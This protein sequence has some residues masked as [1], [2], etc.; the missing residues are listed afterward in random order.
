MKEYGMKLKRCLAMFLSV[1][2]LLTSANIGVLLPIRA[3]EAQAEKQGSTVTLGVLIEKN[4]DELSKEE[5]SIIT[6]GYLSA[7]KTYSYKMPSDSDD[8]ITVDEKS[9]TVTAKAYTDPIYGTVWVPVSFD[10]TD[11]SKAIAGYDNLPLSASGDVYVGTYELEETNPG[12]SFTVAVSYSLDM[13]MSDEDLAA[14]QQMLDASYALATDIALMQYLDAVSVI[15]DDQELADQIIDIS[16]GLIKDPTK[17]YADTILEFL[18]MDLEQLGNQSAIDLIYQ[19]VDGIEI[20]YV[21]EIDFETGKIEISEETLR[22]GKDGRNAA[23]ELYNQKVN[24]NALDLVAFLSK[25]NSASYL[26][27]V[28]VHGTELKS[29]LTGNYAAID[30][31]SNLNSSGGLKYVSNQISV[32]LEDFYAV[33]E[34]IYDE[35]NSYL[36]EM[37]KTVNSV[38]EL[39]ALIAELDAANSDAYNAINEKLAELDADTKALLAEYGAPE[40]VENIDDLTAMKNALV[41]AYTDAIGTINSALAS[42]DSDLLAQLTAAGAPAKITVADTSS[43]EAFV[44]SGDQDIADLEALRTALLKV[45]KDALSEANDMLQSMLGDLDADT[46]T[47]LTAAGAPAKITTVED[48]KTLQTALAKVKADV[49]AQI[50]AELQK[51]YSENADLAPKLISAGAPES[52]KALQDLVDLEAALIKARE[53]LLNTAISSANETLSVLF[54]AYPAI[55]PNTGLPKKIT[56]EAQLR[57]VAAKLHDLSSI[58]NK[59]TIDNMDQAISALDQLDEIIPSIG[60]AKDGVAKLESAESDLQAAADGLDALDDTIAEL[61]TAKTALA[62]M[63]PY[64]A[65]VMEGYEQLALL[66]GTA[67]PLLKQVES[68]MIQLEEGIATLTDKQQQLDM[69]I[70]V[71][72]AFCSTVEPAYNACVNDAWNAP[73]LLNDKADYN[74]LTT[75]A[76]DATKKDYVAKP[77][78]HVADAVVTYKMDMYDVTVEFKAAVVNPAKVDSAETIDLTTKTYVITLTKGATAQEILTEIAAKVDENAILTDWAIS[79]DN[80]D[81]TTNLLPE[82]LE[83]NITYTVTYAPKQL[84]VSF[85]EGYD[86]GTADMKVPYGYRMTLP[87]LVG[88]ATEEYTYT[89]NSENNIDQGTIVTI[90]EDTLISREQGA[91]S[92]KKYLTDLV[93][94][95]TPGMNDLIKNILLNQALNRGKAISIRVPGKDQVVVVPAGDAKSVTISALPFGSRVGDKN[96]IANTAVI[97][98][99]TVN[100]VDGTHVEIINPSFDKVVVNYELALT[101]A[102]LGITDEQLLAVMNIPYELV[103]DYLFQKGMLDALSTNDASTG[104]AE[105]DIMGLLTMLNAQDYVI[106]SPSKMTLKEALGKIEDLN[107]LLELGLGANAVA[108]AKK[109]YNLIPDAG[110]VSLY[111]TLQQYNEQGMIHFYKNETTYINQ[112][113]ELNEIMKELVADEGFI[114]LIPASYMSTFEL[115]QKVLNDAAELEKPENGVNKE[116]INVASPYLSTLLTALE[117][118][119][120]T[121]LTHYTTAPSE[122]VW[123]ASVEKPGPSK[124]TITMTVNFNGV[125]KTEYKIVNFGGQI[126]YAE[127]AQWALTMVK[128]LGLSDEIAAYYTGTYSFNGDIT[129]GQDV[130]LSASWSLKDYDVLVGGEVIGS[131]NYE[132]R[133][134]VLAQHND[135][136]YQYRYYIN[137][138]LY[139]AG[140]HTLTL[141]QFKALTEGKLTIVRDT[142]N[143]AE[144]NLI[145]LIENMNGAAVLTKD[146]NGQYA[147]ILPVNPASVQTDMTNFVIGLFMTDYKYIGLGGNEFYSG[148]FHLQALVDAVMNSGIGTDSLLKLIDSNGNITSNMKLP[149]GTEILNSVKPG[150]VNNLGGVVMESTMN[151]GADANAATHAKFYITLNGTVSQMKQVR[152]GLLQAKNAGISFILKDGS[153]NLSLNLPDQLYGAYLAALSLVGQTDI[154]NVNDVNAKVAIGYILDLLDPAVADDVTT[155]TLTN[156]LK[157]FGISRDLTAYESYFKLLKQY[158]DLENI[159]YTND[160]AS[161]ALNNISIN[162]LLN[163]LQGFVDGMDLPEGISVDLSKLIYEYDDPSTTLDDE[164]SGLDVSAAV[165]VTNLNTDYAALFLDIRAAGVLNKFGMW[166]AN[167]LLAGSD[168]FAGISVV[169]LVDDVVGDLHFNTTTILDLNGK[170]VT[171]NITGGANANVIIIDTAYKSVVP[172][173]V[174]GKVSGN[175]TILEGKYETNVS[176]FLDNGYVQNA[177]GKV[178]NKLFSIVTDENNNITITLNATPADI[179]ELA[180][181]QGLIDLAIEMVASLVINNY[182]NASLSIAGDKIYN[183]SL[184]DIVGLYASSNKLD[185]AI[186]TGLSWISASDLADLVNTLIADLTDFA[187]LEEALRGDGKV[188]SY[189][190]SVAPWKLEIIH[191]T[192]G[193]YLS[194]SLGAS[195]KTEDA[196]LNVVISGELKDNL[197]NLAGGLKDTVNVDVKIDMDDIIRD[198]NSVINLVGSF[199]GVVEIDFTKDPNYV[200]MMAVILADGADSALKAKLVNGIEAYYKHNSLYDLE[201]TFN[202]LTIKQI[203]DCLQNNTRSELFSSM[204]N[205]LALSANVKKTIIN[206]IDNTEMGYKDVIDVIGFVLRQL[207]A[208]N[209][210]ESITENG[211][212]LGSM[213]KSDA[214]GHYYG[215]SGAKAF[216]GVRKI[217][218]NYKLGYDLDISMLSVIVRLFPDHV[219]N[220]QEIVDEKFLKDEATCTS[221]AVYY[222]SC[223]ICGEMS[224]ETFSYGDLKPHEFTAEIVD[225][226]YLKDEATC[227]SL[228]VYYVSC[229]HCGEA[230]TTETF[231]YGELKDHN[232]IFVEHNPATETADGN[233]AYWYCDCCGK[234]FLDE[235]AT[236]EISKEDTVIAALPTIGLPNMAIGGKIYGFLAAEDSKILFIDAVKDGITVEEFQTLIGIA[237]T[238]DFDNLPEVTVTGAYN[239]GSANLICTTAKVT[240]TAENA[241][242]V[243]VSVTYDI[244][245]MGDS[246]CNGRVESGDVI[247]IERHYLGIQN[248]SGLALLAADSN[249]NDRLES[250]DIVKIT[251]KYLDGDDYVTALKK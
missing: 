219:H 147:I 190:T 21:E 30:Y 87:K 16:G 7:D 96:W 117:S 158:Y 106:E 121:E 207:D 71:M 204:V 75:W 43:Y 6:S 168:D 244:V 77:V 39:S 192:E 131:V 76:K 152:N 55:M 50:D 123:V 73:K 196:V 148:Q 221:Q 135:P 195:D 3:V 133:D 210:L 85:G 225:D 171:G 72:Q 232:L 52:I 12:N 88:D 103:N 78:L 45:R 56:T 230:S 189:T 228:A 63:K 215:F 139:S 180:N 170:K 167:E 164:T 57:D 198:E 247:K 18:A 126:T 138:E 10:L 98:G 34:D 163:K 223:P 172:G 86:A 9:G 99:V 69:L 149:A 89:V 206:D 212:T 68:G 37:G 44:N 31:L 136:N 145:K 128:E 83:S 185:A 107:N 166:T 41:G 38:A 35:L 97:D 161:L 125:E 250:G 231:T 109:V 188:L 241:D 150:I 58:L 92:A 227:T 246:N 248:L 90:T 113:T 132:D 211:R 186:D 251:T 42:L 79:A 159:T 81:R 105:D 154:A 194:L 157:K 74:K 155:Q 199:H 202:S 182:N 33:Q 222:K 208:R 226:K 179:K 153:A 209:L 214:I 165:Q 100:L 233:I 127:M 11:G 53:S 4:F 60:Q 64:V 249:R 174:T 217:F 187:A 84:T 8:L 119:I 20:P 141:A 118:A 61:D 134:I 243:K 36:A 26:E 32:M 173:T 129:V 111:Y 218:R 144:A 177:D 13:T 143:L 17:V 220:Y 104:K 120:G 51:I 49:L 59:E 156:T 115:I 216:N 65:Q 229:V 176:A 140:K 181:K 200:I 245:V 91:A 224:S 94:N 242:G 235:A 25:H 101:A 24:N 130:A 191:V 162:A 82:T 112:I 22:L 197:A 238:N 70:L 93:V 175:V 54:S 5:I 146:A 237:M 213:M 201:K 178:T 29:A 203:C 114:K 27:M 28:A 47:K 239:N 15:G 95:T 169:V 102:A 183:I 184:N 137:G 48:L 236:L 160:T 14:Q 193:D 1:V 124:A 108:A 66:S 40:K 80:Y 122:L 67:L 23:T 234:Y 46:R 116:L 2:M 240:L 19:L 62:A 151:F 110:Y 142:I 205:S